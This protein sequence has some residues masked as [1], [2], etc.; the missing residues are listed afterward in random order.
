M[1][2][3]SDRRQI[4]PPERYRT[5]KEAQ[6]AL[7]QQLS[8]DLNGAF[9][10]PT[11][12]S[13]RDFLTAHWLKDI[14]GSVRP[15]TLVK[16]RS[17][18]ERYIVPYFEDSL[19]RK[20]TPTAVADFN[21]N[22]RDSSRRP[23]RVRSGEGAQGDASVSSGDQSASLPPLSPASRRDVYVTLAT[24]L[25]AAV[26]QGLLVRNPASRVAAPRR[27]RSR[28]IR[29]WSKEETAR[30]LS[31]VQ[32]DR[33]YP[34]WRLLVMTGLRRG[35]ALGLKWSDVD[36]SALRASI[37][38][39]RGVV[40]GRVI[41]QPPKTRKGRRFIR[42]DEA[43]ADALAAWKTEQEAERLRCGG[44]WLGEDPL[45]ASWVF[46][47]EDGR[48]PH[49]GSVTKWFWAAEAKVDVQR[50]RLHDLRHT[51]AT[52][53]LEA[54]V[55]VKIVQ[56]QLG[57]ATVAQ[58]IDTYSFAIPSLHEDAAQRVAALVDGLS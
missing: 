24:A 8:A 46:T 20:I 27:E 19:L 12:L 36:L 22:L 5:K 41:V 35:E 4:V 16:Y 44:A 29:Y 42:F 37:Q 48:P 15:S 49:P 52:T 25:N 56:E 58:T 13:L 18:V 39:S 30:F 55:H 10:P 14:S 43:T 33:F 6:Q 53:A 7:T 21:A 23:R 2:D 32:E 11:N 51:Y 26:D 38:R 9:V 31:A 3:T 57:H 47:S 1:L 28:E 54:G 17:H 40:G 50:I 45:E 34:L